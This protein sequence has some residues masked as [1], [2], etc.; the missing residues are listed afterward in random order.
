MALRRHL[1]TERGSLMK[2]TVKNN[3]RKQVPSGSAAIDKT[4]IRTSDDT[5]AAVSRLWLQSIGSTIKDSSYSRYSRIIFDYILPEL[6]D[7]PIDSLDY[8]TINAFKEMLL[9]SGGKKHHGLSAKTVSDILRLPLRLQSHA[10]RA[11]QK[12]KKNIQRNGR[13]PRQGS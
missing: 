2:S 13:Y 11:Y 1:V 5:F 6:A 12:S 9:K 10:D 8:T 3:T 4:N 7:K